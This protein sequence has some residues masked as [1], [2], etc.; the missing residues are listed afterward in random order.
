MRP[1]C[2]SF[3]PA[4]PG[5]RG[6]RAAEPPS[7]DYCGGQ[8][9]DI[10]PPGENGNAT[11]AEILAQPGASAP[12]PRT[13]RTSSARTPTWPPATPTLT[14]A[15]INNFFNDASFGVPAD[16]VASVDQ[17]RGDRRDDHPRQEDRRPAHHRA[18]PAT[19]PSSAPGTRPPRTGCG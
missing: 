10:L 14:D 4:Y 1:R 15:K 19:A 8:C 3:V 5:G 17:A 13:P 12:S 2:R 6:R 18:P 7:N 11:L 9:S 16:Q